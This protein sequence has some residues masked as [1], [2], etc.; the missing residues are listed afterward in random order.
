[1]TQ[2]SSRPPNLLQP[3][4]KAAPTFSSSI[5]AATASTTPQVSRP[6]SRTR[7]PDTERPLPPT[8][9]SDKATASFI[10]RVL[11]P[12]THNTGDRNTSRPI[13]ELLPPLTSSNDVDLQ[14]YA[15]IAIVIK[16]FVY[17]WYAKITPDHVFVEEVV[18]II[19]HCTRALEERLRGVD[20]E[21][22]LFDEIP[23]L[24]ERHII[25]YRT[26]HE[27]LQRPPLRPDPRQVYHTLCPHPALSP[28]PDAEMPST[29]NELQQNEAAYCQL[30]VQG[31]LAVLLPPEDLENACL[32]T[33]V[34]DILGELILRNGIGGK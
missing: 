29:V 8:D 21:E 22:L 2:P 13:S 12:H 28:I 5:L 31:V 9:T 23:E 32:R 3:R 27:P 24:V 1:M 6:S 17:S 10:R 26:A 25:A 15:I 4:L 7:E 20:L 11:C 33:L 16:E 19:A 30:L 18:Q 34:T 14:L